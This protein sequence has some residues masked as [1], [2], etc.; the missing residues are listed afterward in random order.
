MA[1]TKARTNDD[2]PARL[3]R[4]IPKTA[5]I[6]DAILE[7]GYSESTALKSGR[8]TI[9]TA[10]ENISE[11]AIEGDTEAARLLTLVGI[12]REQLMERYRYI[13]MESQSHA[14]SLQAL[15]PILR[16]VGLDLNAG[17]EQKQAPPLI[18]G[19]QNNLKDG[20]T[21]LR[22]DTQQA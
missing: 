8:R 9:D 3:L 21:E 1:H 13:A 15:Q 7:A 14:V 18:I 6:K 5:T 4:A 22:H 19:I 17:N 12:S 2:R 20:S 16:T 10:L 11:R